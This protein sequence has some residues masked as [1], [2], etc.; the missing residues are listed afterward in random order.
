MAATTTMPSALESNPL[1]RAA[2]SLG[3]T[4]R[5]MAR[6][7]AGLVGLVLVAIFILMGIF[8]P[9]FARSPVPDVSA[10]YAAPSATH[11][12]GTDSQGRDVLAQVIRGGRVLLLI[13]IIG[14]A[15]S[16][17]IAM[18]LGALAAVF[19][20][21]MDSA[22]VTVTDFVL[23]I[24]QTPLLFV[25][26]GFLHF[27]N[28]LF[29]AVIIGLLDWPGLTRSIRAQLFSLK[30]RDYVEAAR[31]LGLSNRRIM[32]SELLPN[33][34]AYI[35]ISFALSM[36]GAI[37]QATGLYFLGF[38]PLVGDNWGIMINLAWT[39]GAIF[40]QNS[41]AYILAP[42]AAIVLVSIGLVMLSRSMEEV[43]NPRLRGGL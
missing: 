22:V 23:T 33:M 17:A 24:P 43:F 14:A 32:F 31:S 28:P 37:Y 36:V 15:I 7:P 20:G 38:A 30:Q 39:Q 6:S 11:A 18:T 4:L 35:V 19:G 3:T 25:L 42:V 9:I 12:L 29:I 10:I 2:R 21:G 1:T 34:M 41:L 5:L 40:F 16:T 27:T 13:A 26:A 8:G